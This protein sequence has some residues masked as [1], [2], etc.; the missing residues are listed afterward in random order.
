MPLGYC[1]VEIGA[2]FQK[3]LCDGTPHIAKLEFLDFSIGFC[4]WALKCPVS[5]P[6]TQKV[7]MRS[8]CFS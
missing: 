4:D 3:S 2:A 1:L 6:T 8:P 7:P 5:S